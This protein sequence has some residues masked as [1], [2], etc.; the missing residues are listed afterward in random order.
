MEQREL[1]LIKDIF[2]FLQ[3][4]ISESGV[5]TS[6]GFTQDH[7]DALKH[8]VLLHQEKDEQCSKH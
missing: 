8:L 1:E 7:I 3:G 5:M 6:T 2:W 4:A